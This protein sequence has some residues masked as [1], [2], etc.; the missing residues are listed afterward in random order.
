MANT[1]LG[2]HFTTQ[3]R[4]KA[5]E[6]ALF[7]AFSSKQSKEQVELLLKMK[8]L[9][10]P[11]NTSTTVSTTSST[12]LQAEWKE[13]PLPPAYLHALK[14]F[15]KEEIIVT[16]FVDQALISE[17]LLASQESPHSHVLTDTLRAHFLSEFHIAII[18]YNLRIVSRYYTRI[19]MDR[20]AALLSLRV[21][22]VEFHLSDLSFRG[23]IVV[24][25][26]RPQGLAVFQ[27]NK[28]ADQVL[29]DWAKNI[30]NLL[31]LMETTG[32]LIN[33]ENMVYK[34]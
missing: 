4:A 10:L 1:R 3:Q 23:D 11:T 19:R 31:E 8:S 15:L 6:F 30:S 17:H 33:R 34:V 12:S 14:L 21:E 9:L 22:E 20:L 29:T 16:P 25:I 13:L 2:E 32:H 5:M 27:V 24:K 18:E 7:Y 28:N 26:D